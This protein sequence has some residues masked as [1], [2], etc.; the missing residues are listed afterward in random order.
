M[1]ILELFYLDKNNTVVG[2]I[3]TVTVKENDNVADMANQY[4]TGFQDLL[5]ANPESHHW[6]PEPHTNY[7]TIYVYTSSKKLQ[8]YYFESCRIKIIFLYEK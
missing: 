8:W 4:K 2:S 1:H 5:I 7:L 3:R 6:S